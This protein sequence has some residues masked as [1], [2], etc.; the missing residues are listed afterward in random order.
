[1]AMSRNGLS[2]KARDEIT[3]ELAAIRVEQEAL[4]DHIRAVTDAYENGMITHPE[5][6]RMTFDIMNAQTVLT[7]RADRLYK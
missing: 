3:V 1:M 6:V 4:L 7:E 5:L 2:Q